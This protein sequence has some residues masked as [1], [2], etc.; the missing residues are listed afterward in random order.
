MPATA[1][2]FAARRA[3]T[4]ACADVVFVEPDV[5]VSNFGEVMVGLLE[6]EVVVVCWALAYFAM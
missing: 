5:G 1:I 3:A 2:K 6:V 4:A